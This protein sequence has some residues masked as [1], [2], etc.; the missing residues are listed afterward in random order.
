MSFNIIDGTNNILSTL[1]VNSGSLSALEFGGP[2]GPQGF[3]G[4]DGPQGPQ[5]FTGADGPQGPQGPT[6]S[7]GFT[8]PESGTGFI[9]LV[10]P[11]GSNDVFFSNSLNIENSQINIGLDLKPLNNNINLGSFDNDFKNL[12][13]KNL[14]GTDGGNVTEYTT[15][16]IVIEQNVEAGDLV[17]IE[18]WGAGGNNA[19]GSTPGIGGIGGYS[20]TSFSSPEN[21]TLQIVVGSAGGGGLGG[22]NLTGQGHNGGNGGGASYVYYGTT[23]SYNLK[24]VAGGG[25]GGGSTTGPPAGNG[26]NSTQNGQDGTSIGG[27][28][29]TL[30]SAGSPGGGGPMMSPVSTVTTSL[31]NN[32]GNANNVNNSTPLNLGGGGG[33]GY[34]GGG[35]GENILANPASAGGGGGGSNFGDETLADGTTA[36]SYP[37]GGVSQA[38]NNGAVKVTI[39]KSLINLNSSLNPGTTGIDLGSINS[40][41]QDFSLAGVINSTEGLFVN[42]IQGV[43]GVVNLNNLYYNSSNS[44]VIFQSPSYAGVSQEGA[45]NYTSFGSIISFNFDWSFAFN[46]INNNNIS[47]NSSTNQFTIQVPGVY[48]MMYTLQNL[49]NN[50]WN[51]SIRKGAAG[52]VTSILVLGG[53]FC[54]S[55]IIDNLSA[56]DIIALVLTSNN[57]PSTLT[58]FAA[59]FSILKIA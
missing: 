35:Y 11:T 57:I 17:I 18:A 14:S 41:F 56:G 25:G 43:T 4:A 39:I 27:Q 13:I 47:F 24:A 8:I 52:Y 29:A 26:G 58:T 48:Q 5:G 44:E 42:G 59:S 20:K 45:N 10:N 37:G 3:T 22:I 28:G 9:L 53:G 55:I 38:G 7:Q 12:F 21:N 36:S 34:F 15:T 19:N 6:G 2:T 30:L 32:G 23:G 54:S 40:P 33:A 49:A 50:N 46:K 16:D 51:V 1:Y 31:D